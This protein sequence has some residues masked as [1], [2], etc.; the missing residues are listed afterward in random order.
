MPA[1]SSS[2]RR[3]RARDAHE[4]VARIAAEAIFAQLR[5]DGFVIMRRQPAPIQNGWAGAGPFA[6]LE[7]LRGQRRVAHCRAC[8]HERDLDIEGLIARGWGETLIKEPHWCAA[9]A[10]HR[11]APLSVAR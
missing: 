5:A 4:L 2:D 10:D 6:Q 3:R 9:H 7:R 1:I 8:G 11:T